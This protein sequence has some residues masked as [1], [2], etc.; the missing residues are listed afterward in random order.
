MNAYF[1][2]DFH[3]DCL[4]RLLF[5]VTTQFCALLPSLLQANLAR[6]FDYL[7]NSIAFDILILQSIVHPDKRC[8]CHIFYCLLFFYSIFVADNNIKRI[9]KNF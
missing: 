1:L 8:I 3:A 7:F 2:L 4:A 5:T 9:Q 6:A